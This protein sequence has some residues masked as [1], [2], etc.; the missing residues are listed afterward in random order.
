MYI[1]SCFIRLPWI[2]FAGESRRVAAVAI[3]LAVDR[4]DSVHR[5]DARFVRTR[6]ISFCRKRIEYIKEKFNNVDTSRNAKVFVLA[7]LV[8]GA[9]MYLIVSIY[10]VATT[11]AQ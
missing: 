10:S 9:Y 2:S 8:L 1:A 6:L 5:C 7:L 3:L 4:R 11:V